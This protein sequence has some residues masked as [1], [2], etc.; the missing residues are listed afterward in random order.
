[1]CHGPYDPLH[2]MQDMARRTQGV[3][4]PRWSIRPLLAAL[5]G[6]IRP[7]AGWMPTRPARDLRPA[8]IRRDQR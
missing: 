6:W 1:M 8:H 3:H 2:L 5:G 4:A 7:M